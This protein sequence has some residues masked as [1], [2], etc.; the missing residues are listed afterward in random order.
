MDRLGVRMNQKHSTCVAGVIVFA[1]LLLLA[2]VPAIT[3]YG[4]DSIDSG[5]SYTGDAYASA[6]DDNSQ[7]ADLLAEAYDGNA[8][9]HATWRKDFTVNTTREHDIY[10]RWEYKGEISVE[11]ESDVALMNSN[12]KLW[13]ETTGTGVLS[14]SWGPI[15]PG[16]YDSFVIRGYIDTP[17][18]STHEYYWQFYAR[19]AAYSD[20]GEAISDF[21]GA[22]YVKWVYLSIN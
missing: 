11:E 1:A 20:T 8:N 5:A 12:W 2:T 14:E 18:D 7:F 16:T 15:G 6:T 4:A 17:L 9:A 10:F 13:D 22:G 21:Y 19:A 3:Y